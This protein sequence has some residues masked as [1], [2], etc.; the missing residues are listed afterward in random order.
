MYILPIEYPRE[1]VLSLQ[2]VFEYYHMHNL[3]GPYKLDSTNSCV[4]F[5][6]GLPKVKTFV[7]V[8]AFKK[9]C[10]VLL[11]HESACLSV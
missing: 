9:A 2:R 6:Y 8:V 1:V 5:D 11:Y 10:G 7:I 4:N 3:S